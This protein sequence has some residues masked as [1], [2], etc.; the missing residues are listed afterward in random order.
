MQQSQNT[1]KRTIPNDVKESIITRK[2]RLFIDAP[3]NDKEE[4]NKLY[5]KL[6]DW[7]NIVFKASNLVASHLF[8]QEQAQELIY[9]QDN[10]KLKLVKRQNDDIG[11]LNTSQCNSIYRLI[12]QKFKNALPTAISGRL[13]YTVYQNFI[14]EKQQYFLGEKSLRSYK[15]DIPVPFPPE[16]LYDLNYDKEIN[17]FRFSLFKR[18]SYKIPFR[19]FLGKDL[20]KNKVIMDRCMR[21]EYKLCSS[22]YI[23]KKGKI[24]LLLTAKIPRIKHE[25]KKDLTAQATLSFLTPIL[26]TI[27]SEQYQIGDKESYLYKRLAIQQGLKRR[28]KMMKYNAGGKGR[29]KKTKGVEAF[30]SKENQFIE[31]YMHNLSRAL[32]NLCIEHRVGQLELKELVQSKEETKEIPFVLRNWS[33]GSLQA[34]I[35]YKC[36]MNGID[37]ITT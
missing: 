14:N 4:L 6:Y 20:S 27:N 9:F 1:S 33:I 16:A 21:G 37:L 29:E 30:K 22:A 2:I 7:Q 10:V 34:K 32:I 11:M 26:V 31:N 28:Q 36:K 5:R 23:I 3:N 24:F 12:S 17:N 8:I 19:T 35:E 18:T 13:S 15:R 25:L